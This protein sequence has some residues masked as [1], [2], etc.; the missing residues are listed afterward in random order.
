MFCCDWSFS[1][2]D[3]MACPPV[4]A[5]HCREDQFLVEV[6][7]EKTCCYSYLCGKLFNS[8]Y[9]RRQLNSEVFSVWLA[10]CYFSIYYTSI[11]YSKTKTECIVCVSVWAVCESCIEPIPTC[12]HG[13][14]LAVDLNN[15]NSCCPQYHCGKFVCVRYC[16]YVCFCTF[17]FKAIFILSLMCCSLWCQPVPW[18]NCELCAWAHCGSDYCPWALLPPA[19][20]WYA[21]KLFL[22]YFICTHKIVHKIQ[23]IKIIRFVSGEDKKPQS[24]PFD[25]PS[26]TLLLQQKINDK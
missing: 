16:A 14:I 9:V 21:L 3:P 7:G 23:I 19:P 25:L 20:L 12:S 11:N 1:E 24:Y 22:F 18:I 17:V 8:S 4:S 5:P 2:C 10:F 6:R 15:T 13:E 26:K